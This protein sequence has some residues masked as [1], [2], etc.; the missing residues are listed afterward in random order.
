MQTNGETQSDQVHATRPA[1]EELPDAYSP[2]E[3]TTRVETAGVAKCK[4]SCASTFVLGILAGIYIGFGANFYTIVV[5]A[6]GT[7]FGITKLLG[8]LAFCLGLILVV[9]GG[10][11]LFTGNNLLFT[12]WASRK[13]TTGQLLRNWVIVYLGN[14]AGSVL[15]VLVAYGAEQ[16]RLGDNAVG[17]TAL[18]VAAGKVQLSFLAC[19]CRGILCNTLVCL[20]VWLCFSARSTTG[21]ILSILFPITAFVAGGF[22]HC[23]ANMYFVPM[24]LF[25]RAQP[26]VV[27]AIGGIPAQLTWPGFLWYNLVPATLG[28]IVG[29]CLF[30][31]GAYWLAYRPCAI[32]KPTDRNAA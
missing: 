5:T 13:L 15:L 17:I 22:E 30:V 14:F 32:R 2:P 7:G 27:S 10:A 20:A 6:T 11:E 19:F 29:G 1:R 8:G 31:G 12:G 25:L 3:M 21:K 28:N 16:W 4:L 26:D 24:G 9:V 23:V 18:N